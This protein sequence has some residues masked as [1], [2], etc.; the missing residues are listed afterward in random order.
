MVAHRE[1]P[2]LQRDHLRQAVIDVV[3]RALEDVQLPL[4]AGSAIVEVDLAVVQMWAV[5]LFQPVPLGVALGGGPLRMQIDALL[6]M[7][8][9]AAVG[10]EGHRAFG[11]EQLVFVGVLPE[12]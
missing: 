6:E 10:D 2:E 4:P 12:E 11:V 1:R 5:E 7:V 9:L 8:D 3:E